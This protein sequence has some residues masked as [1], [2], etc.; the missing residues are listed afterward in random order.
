MINCL[1]IDDE[2]ASRDILETYIKDT[3]ELNLIALCKNALE[4]NVMLKN[5]ANIHLLFLDINMPKLNGMDFYK[6]LT[7]PP[8]VIFTT[9]YPEYA[10]EGFE[11]EAVDFLLKPFPY[12][13]FLKAVNKASKLLNTSKDAKE[14]FITLKADKKMHR[15]RLYDIIRLESVGDYVKLFFLDKSILVH[16][17]MT[18]ILKK[19]PS[20]IFIRTHKSHVINFLKL[21]SVEGNMIHLETFNVPIGATYKSEVEKKLK[22]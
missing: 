15:I 14:E 20:H 8:L 1:I 6:A 9:A 19:L 4:A 16:D 17:T 12:A 5:N 22:L 21:E 18:N 11:V 13:R 10:I 3:E 7:T 2:P